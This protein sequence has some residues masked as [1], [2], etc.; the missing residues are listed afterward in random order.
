MPKNANRVVKRNIGCLEIEDTY[1]FLPVLGNQVVRQTIR[2]RDESNPFVGKE[3]DEGLGLILDAFADVAI[4]NPFQ[5]LTF[6]EALEC[7]LEIVAE[8]RPALVQLFRETYKRT[9]PGY[10]EYV[11]VWR[12]V[13]EDRGDDEGPL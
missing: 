7:L 4:E 6:D 11:T 3:F 10:R 9:A 5:R 2:I 1:Q 13:N 12:N 8:R